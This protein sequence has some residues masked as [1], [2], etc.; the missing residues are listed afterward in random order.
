MNIV[1]VSGSPTAASRSAWL[2]QQALAALKGRV[3]QAFTIAARELPA[4]A[5]CSA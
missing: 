4:E 1:I 3:A 5:R 2:A